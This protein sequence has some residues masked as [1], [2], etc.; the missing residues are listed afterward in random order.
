MGFPLPSD[1]WPYVH[2]FDVSQKA[3]VQIDASVYPIAFRTGSTKGRG[4]GKYYSLVCMRPGECK[5]VKFVSRD[6]FMTLRKASKGGSRRKSKCNTKSKR[7]CKKS[8]TCAY[9]P[10]RKATRTKSARKSYCRKK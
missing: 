3:R 7:S 5:L 4:P 8:K 1:H 6:T 9:V 2:F 10:R